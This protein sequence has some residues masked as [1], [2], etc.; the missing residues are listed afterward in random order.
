VTHPTSPAAMTLNDLE[1]H[2]CCLKPTSENI[3]RINCDVFTRDSKKH[4]ACKF[5]CLIETGGL[6]K[7]AGN[8]SRTLEKW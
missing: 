5:N 7:V 4:V 8:L 1:R 3:A 2:F 6:F